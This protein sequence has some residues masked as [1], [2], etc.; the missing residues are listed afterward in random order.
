MQ[1]YKLKHLTKQKT[2]FLIKALG[3]G[4]VIVYPTETSY[5]IGCDSADQLAVKKIFKIKRRPVNKAMTLLA[6]DLVMAR[7]YLN[8]D[9]LSLELAKKYW[10]G[11]LTL[12]LTKKSVKGQIF[13][14][15]SGK[16]QTIGIR[17][18]SNNIATKLVKGLG[19]PIITT[20]A[21]ITGQQPA[22]DVQKIINYFKDKK[23]Q[24]DIIIDAGP[25]KK[26]KTSTVIEIKNGKINILRQGPIKI[27]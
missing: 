11:P 6:S 4:K 18:S 17:L 23:Y 10:P 9:N 26:Q 3:E 25:L 8:F 21:N 1:I 13:A 22:Y 16:N 14:S 20:S 24:P 27:K 12:V 5:G 2:L 7:R 19:R 15:A